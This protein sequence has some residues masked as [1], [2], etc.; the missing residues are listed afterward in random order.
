MQKTIVLLVV[1]INFFHVSA[2][3]IKFD[4]S[5]STDHLVDKILLGNG[6]RVGNVKMTGVKQS[7][8]YFKTDSNVLGMTSGLILS[9]GNAALIA[10]PNS[11]PSTT[12]ISWDYSKSKIYK[13]DK[14]LNMLCEDITCDHV[15]LE[16][17]FVP[18]NNHVS[19]KFIFAS[20]EYPEYVG[21]IYN[22]VFAFIVTGENIKKKNLAVIPGTD[23]PVTINTINHQRNKH[24]FI[25]NNYFIGGYAAKNDEQVP[26]FRKAGHFLKHLFKKK[27]AS[28]GFTYMPGEKAKLNQFL[29]SNFEFDGLTRVM[30]A[31]CILQPWKLY[32]LK[33]AVGDVADQI[34]DSGVL[35]EEGSFSSIKDTA[36]T[37]FKDYPDMYNQLNWDSIF[38][39]KPMPVDSVPGLTQEFEI[40]NINFEFD[41]FE[42]PGTAAIKLDSLAIYLNQH[43]HFTLTMKGFA[44]NK[45][46]RE[47]NLALSQKRALA[48]AQY[49]ILKNVEA[50]RLTYAGHGYDNP[51]ADNLI[52]EG[53]SLNRRVEL[54]LIDNSPTTEPANTRR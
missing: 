34:L 19:F 15:V 49:L 2:Q 50:S 43:K 40:T 6:M 27:S 13:G 4:T 42:I 36:V 11:R 52:A 14:D 24:L 7:I 35:L 18:Y 3:Q 16:F 51:V 30:T 5:F 32:H 23:Q 10:Q 12:G 45:G 41:K 17:D 9:T 37:G 46:N 53:R 28:N 33:I 20:E 38:K 47:Y 22:D 25:N 29:V 44:D 21:S 31:S 26:L 1:S 39:V 48:V 8:C 54:V